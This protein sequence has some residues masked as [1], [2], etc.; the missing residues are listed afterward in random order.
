MCKNS[1][2]HLNEEVRL[3]QLATTESKITISTIPGSQFLLITIRS[4]KPLES[5]SES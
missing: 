1:L 5:T 2:N 3:L 4:E